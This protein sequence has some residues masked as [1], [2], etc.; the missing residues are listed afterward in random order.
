[1]KLI[2]IA[3]LNLKRGTSSTNSELEG[4]FYNKELIR[5]AIYA[6]AL[7]DPETSLRIFRTPH[8]K[9]IKIGILITEDFYNKHV[10]RFVKEAQDKEI[11]RWLSEIA[12]R[13]APKLIWLGRT[14]IGG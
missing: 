5:Q 10:G 11:N 12:L 3:T 4:Y 6:C 9:Y 13:A 1:M 2:D 7:E 8:D 14:G